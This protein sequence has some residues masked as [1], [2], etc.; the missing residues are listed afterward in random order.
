MVQNFKGDAVELKMQACA[1]PAFQI[2]GTALDSF[3]EGGA[4]SDPFL[5]MLYD[6]K[7]MPFSDRVTRNVFVPFIK[8]ALLNFPFIGNFESY[9]FI[10]KEIFG[11]D[12]EVIF[13]VPAE[14][15]LLVSVNAAAGLSFEAIGREYKDGVY[16][17]FNLITQDGEQIIFSGIAGIETEK[18]LSLLFSEIIPAGIFPEISLDF[19]SKSV[20]I[21]YE[22]TDIFDVT[23]HIGNQIIFIEFGD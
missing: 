12:A 14:G 16:E 15:H 20:F 11:A 9:I 2:T 3:L 19:F 4:D 1:T 23:D 22:G 18:E 21:G 6:E 13:D 8:K 7:R 10:L 5:L 17:F